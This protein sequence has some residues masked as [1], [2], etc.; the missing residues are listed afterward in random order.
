MNY[1]SS[2]NKQPHYSFQVL[3]RWKTNIELMNQKK[4]LINLV[5]SLWQSPKEIQL[6]PEDHQMIFYA[7]ENH[8]EAQNN[9]TLILGFEPAEIINV[10]RTPSC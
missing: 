1:L 2:V 4:K 9:I 8:N 3:E 10:T 7:D 5:R 6:L